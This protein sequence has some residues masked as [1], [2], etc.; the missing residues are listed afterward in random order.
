MLYDKEMKKMT[1]NTLK[2]ACGLRSEIY[3]LVKDVE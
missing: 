2:I 3:S 1:E